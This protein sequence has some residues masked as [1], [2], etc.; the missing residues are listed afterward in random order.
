M[1]FIDLLKANC[2]EGKLVNLTDPKT[3]RVLTKKGK[4]KFGYLIQTV[5]ET[6]TGLI[7]MQNVVPEQT[8]A[9]QLINAIDY[10]YQNY[11]RLPKYMLADNGYYQITA[12]EYAFYLGVK[13]SYPRSKRK[14]EE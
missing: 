1:N 6:K 2:G 12:L 11:A 7:L 4:V 5:T 13:S 9:N 3:H 8:D 14:Y 10:I